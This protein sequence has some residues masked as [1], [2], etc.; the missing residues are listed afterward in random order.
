MCVIDPIP[1]KECKTVRG[2]E[3]G[4]VQGV[5]ESLR[6][7]VLRSVSNLCGVRKMGARVRGMLVS[8]RAMRL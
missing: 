3:L 6:I 4:N 5:L 8:R 1:Y 7:A 2:Q